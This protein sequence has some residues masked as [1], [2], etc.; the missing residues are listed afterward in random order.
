[1][2]G[3][4]MDHLISRHDLGMLTVSYTTVENLE[5]CILK[6]TYMETSNGLKS[7]R[8]LEKFLTAYL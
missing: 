3:K 6:L 1:M 5:K 8:Q 2:L 7:F 4:C